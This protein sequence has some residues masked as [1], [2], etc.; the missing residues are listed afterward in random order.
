M[1]KQE[2]KDI[3]SNH[4]QAYSHKFKVSCNEKPLHPS[5]K[6]F[7][8]CIVLRWVVQLLN[9][10]QKCSRNITLGQR[11]NIISPQNLN[12][13]V[14]S[15]ASTLN[16][17]KHFLRL[18]V[19]KEF[20]MENLKNIVVTWGRSASRSQSVWSAPGWE[21][22]ISKFYQLLMKKNSRLCA[23]YLQSRSISQGSTC[24]EKAILD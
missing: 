4:W 1:S 16:V 7:Y 2:S 14:I 5:L 8:D 18:T 15:W 19:L 9:A 13:H 24:W 21:D 23:V 11:S 20:N 22:M 17:T 6:M 12:P 10:P 3:G